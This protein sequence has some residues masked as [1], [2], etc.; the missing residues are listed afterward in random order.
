VIEAEGVLELDWWKFRHLSG[1]IFSVICED[2]NRARVE[3]GSEG[4]ERACEF[5]VQGRRG[6]GIAL[7]HKTWNKREI[8][9]YLPK[10]NQLTA[11]RVYLEEYK[12]SRVLPA[13]FGMRATDQ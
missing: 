3:L 2:N 11:G 7:R 6:L 10:L 5:N 4:E 9:D 12:A 8:L 1:S 13:W